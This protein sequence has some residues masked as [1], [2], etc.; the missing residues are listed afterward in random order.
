MGVAMEPDLAAARRGYCAELHRA[1]QAAGSTAA[2]SDPATRRTYAPDTQAL[3]VFG[4]KIKRAAKR[5]KQAIALLVLELPD[6]PELETVFGRE[7]AGQA[8]HAVLRVLSR[9]A[10]ADGFAVRTAAD[11]FALLVP[12]VSGGTLERALRGRLGYACCVEFEFHGEEIV[13]VPTVQACT[14]GDQDSIEKTYRVLCRSIQSEKHIEQM[15][16]DHAQRAREVHSTVMDLLPALR[17]STPIRPQ[18]AT[19]GA[20]ATIPATILMPIGR[21]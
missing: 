6:L 8:V 12:E 9:L 1:G 2:S 5:N 16:L 21:K 14:V 4:E 19:P 18:R 13:L 20:Y 10:G 15:R 11:T 7:A 17:E 3:F